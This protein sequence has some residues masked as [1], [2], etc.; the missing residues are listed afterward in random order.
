MSK[1]RK[2]LLL[3]A[4]NNLTRVAYPRAFEITWLTMTSTK[5]SSLGKSILELQ[6]WDGQSTVVAFC[7]V[8]IVKGG[9]DSLL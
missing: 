5:R 9:V 8:N 2:Q 4:V 7:I 3:P 6:Q 1:Q